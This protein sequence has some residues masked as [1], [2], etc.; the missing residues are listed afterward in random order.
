[1]DKPA[2]TMF[3]DRDKAKQYADQKYN[4]GYDVWISYL[5]SFVT[6]ELRGCRG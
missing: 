3:L 4:E 5:G 2:A 1:M 6:V